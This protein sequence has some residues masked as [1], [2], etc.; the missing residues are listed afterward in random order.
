[1]TTEGQY[2]RMNHSVN[3]MRRGLSGAVAVSAAMVA[4]FAPLSAANAQGGAAPAAMIASL[5][6]P[7]PKDVM[8]FPAVVTG[9][10]GSVAPMTPQVKLVQEIVTEAVQEYLRKGGVGSVVYS[11]RLASVQRAVSSGEGLKPEDAA[12]GPGDDPRLAQKFADIIGASEYILVSVDNYAYDP[13]TRRTTFNLSLIR[14]TT[15]GTQLGTS[16]EKAVG[17]APSDVS[18]SHQE[19]ASIARAAQVVA[20][21]GVVNIYPQA[22]GMIYP[23]KMAPQK[24]KGRSSLSWIIPVAAVGALLAV[25]R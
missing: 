23:P 22:A 24:K 17:D 25:P 3:R 19:G 10:N 5:N 1:M 6:Q 18:A 15:D 20:E 21:R 7:L 4:V 13:A 12:K 11:N 16:A 8:L 2:N 9:A 14:A